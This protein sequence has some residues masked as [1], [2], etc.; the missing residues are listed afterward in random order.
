[1]PA[2]NAA[3]PV[4]KFQLATVLFILAVHL[5]SKAVQV[6]LQMP[7]LRHCNRYGRNFTQFP[8]SI[9]MV[10]NAALLQAE[11]RIFMRIVFL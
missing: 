3:V 10:M 11:A 6:G 7:V 8:D 2:F 1:M 5:I 9:K 4:K